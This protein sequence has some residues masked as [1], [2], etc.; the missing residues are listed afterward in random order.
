MMIRMKYQFLIKIT[1]F[2]F[3]NIVSILCLY[4]ISYLLT[5][6]L[7]SMLGKE[8]NY[9]YRFF[10]LTFNVWLSF[11]TMLFLCFDKVSFFIYQNIFDQKKTSLMFD[12]IR[13]FL[14]VL[15]LIISQILP[16]ACT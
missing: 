4:V 12:V 11:A 10:S 7:L 1:I 16:F 3:I 9:D 8:C 15:V 5:Y 2:I 6:L 13:R 14:T